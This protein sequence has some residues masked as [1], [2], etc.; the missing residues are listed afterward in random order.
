MFY[1]LNIGKKTSENNL[2]VRF[3]INLAPPFLDDIG[4]F[5]LYSSSNFDAHRI[6]KRVG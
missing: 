5:T 2:D 6:I 1:S 4:G 3:I